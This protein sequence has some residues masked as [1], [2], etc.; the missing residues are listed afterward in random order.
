MER[1]SLYIKK[2]LGSLK[3]VL[4]GKDKNSRRSVSLET[5]K[6]FVANY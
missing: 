4:N 5:L 6:M 1:P 2:L 3:T